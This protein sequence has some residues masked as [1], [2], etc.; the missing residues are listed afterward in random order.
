VIRLISSEW[1]R[2]RSRRLVKVLTALTVIG[3][4]VAI[5]IAALN[6]HRPTVDELAQAR[7]EADLAV[8]DCIAQGG[9]G[10]VEPGGDVEGF[11]REFADPA[12]FLESPPMRRSEFP[13]LVRGSSF[14]AILLGL[15]IGASAVGA[16]WQS[17]TMTT[18]LSWEPRR[19]R[20]ALVRAAVV[21]VACAVLVV[22]LF[23]MFGAVFWLATGLR[24][25]TDIPPGWGAETV[26][27]IARVAALAACASVIGGAIAMIGR[28]TAAALGAVFVYLAVL[29][30]IVRGLRPGIG[31]FLLS[32]SLAAV[33]IGGDVRLSEGS[34]VTP[35]RAAVVVAVYTLGLFAIASVAFRARDVQ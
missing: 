25:L 7:R 2:V 12:S 33:V 6:S 10:E 11:C 24:G 35:A 14:V 8:E 21:A 22:I 26:E 30:G 15:V 9:Y 23:A 1:L 17:G 3:I 16:S 34:V 28:N 5:G 18:I 31:R 19:V 32:D 27:T 4:V 13:E 29:E 20:F